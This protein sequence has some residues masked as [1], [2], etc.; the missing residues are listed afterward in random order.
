MRVLGQLRALGRAA[1]KST[2][3]LHKWDSHR[4][5]SVHER[6][7]VTDTITRA[8]RRLRARLITSPTN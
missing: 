1:Y 2:D 5:T 4:K 6:K 3:K 7:N 8:L